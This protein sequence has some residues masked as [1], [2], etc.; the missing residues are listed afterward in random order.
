MNMKL[1]IFAGL[2][3]AALALFSSACKK[4]TPFGSELLED[5]YADSEFTDTLTVQCTLVREDSVITSDKSAAAFFLCGAIKDAVAGQYSS[6]IYSLLL[7]E[8][9]NPKFENPTLDSIVLYLKYAPLGVYGDTLQPQTLRVVRLGAQLVRDSSYYSTASLPEAEEL[10]RIDN[11]LPR[12]TRSDSLFEGNEGAFQRIRLSDA[13]GNEL[14]NLDSASWQSDSAFFQKFRGLKITAST[15]GAH[16]G[17]M[18]AYDLNDNKL[19]RVALYY[20]SEGDTAQSRFDFFFRNANK[21]THFEHNYTGSEVGPQIGKEADDLLYLQGMHGIKVK[22]SFPYANQLDHIAVN[23]AQLVLTVADNN[24]LLTPADQLVFTESAGDT[25][26]NYT[27]DVLFSLGS[28]GTGTLKTFG[29]FPEKEL[30]NGIAFTRYRMTLSEKFQHIID[31]DASPNI[32]HRTVFINVFPRNRSA[33][34][35]VVF[36]PKSSTF[37]AKL[38]L[39]YTRVK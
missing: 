15:N 23:K 29:G 39:K 21:F 4:P 18:L 16:P 36:G 2:F 7:A 34:R 12:P 10:G 22:V 35:T 1:P 28:T 26:Y 30:I 8:T 11:F 19:S 17:A 25:T 38:E 13:F 33:R 31:D 27:S 6:D 37:P 9:L 3:L 20:H 14:L 32:K 5:E 24:T